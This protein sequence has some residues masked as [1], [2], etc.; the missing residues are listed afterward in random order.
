MNQFLQTLS[1]Q[2]G[3]ILQAIFEHLSMS[4]LALLIAVLIAIPLAILVAH[5]RRAA[6][7]LLQVTGVFQT[8]PS[9]AILGL[10]IPFVGIGTVPTIIALIVYALLPI[11]Q[12]TY[13]GLAEIDPALL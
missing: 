11:F 3:E 7:I 2:K 5:R 12:N 13:V 4:L 10:L 9:L 1:Q 6:G 8:I